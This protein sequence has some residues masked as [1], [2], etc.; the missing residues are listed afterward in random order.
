MENENF[1]ERLCYSCRLI[2]RDNVNPKM[3]EKVIK[4]KKEENLKNKIKDYLL[5]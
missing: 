1:K 3:F 4:E 2:L 5:E